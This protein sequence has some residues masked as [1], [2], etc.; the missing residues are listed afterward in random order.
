[1]SSPEKPKLKGCDMAVLL[2]QGTQALPVVL[3]RFLVACPV[4]AVGQLSEKFIDNARGG[5]S[6][7]ILASLIHGS[8]LGETRRR[9]HISG[10]V[11]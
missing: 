1:M 3:L 2:L 8:A 6:E 11:G 9:V 10:S 4:G 7:L 5:A